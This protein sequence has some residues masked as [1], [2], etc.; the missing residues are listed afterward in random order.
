MASK[1]PKRIWVD[2]VGNWFSWKAD[3][4]CI[5]Y[6]RVDRKKGKVKRGK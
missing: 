1:P 5:Q 2:V 3:G 4:Y 6:V